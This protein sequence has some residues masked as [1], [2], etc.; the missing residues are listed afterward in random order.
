M[1]CVK[2]NT[3]NRQ[4]AK[5]C[6]QCGYALGVQPRPSFLIRHKK[7][8]IA[9]FVVFLVVV[10]P[11]FLLFTFFFVF[12]GRFAEQT[13]KDTVVSGSGENIIALVH[14]DGIIVE[15]EPAGGIGA[16]AQESTSVRKMKKILREAASS[17]K[18]KALFLKINSPGGSAAASE[19]IYQDLL[20]FK[21]ESGKKIVAYVSDIAAS[22]GYYVAMAAD[23]V[24][25]NPASITGSIGVMISYLNVEALAERFGVKHIVYK[26]GPFKDLLNEFRKPTEEESVIIQNVVNESYENFMRVVVSGRQLP[27]QE[28]RK[29]A[30]GR[31]YS[32]QQAK[33]LKLIDQIGTFEDAVVQAKS[34][35]SL[36]EASVVEFGQPS[37]WELFLGNLASRF[38]ISLSPQVD[39]FFTMGPGLRVLYL[40][41]P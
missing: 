1:N 37:F 20:R 26:T 13:E 35:V 28:V 3:S 40:Y 33:K 31:I 29:I 19:E 14:I 32:A 18:V 27:P 8:V 22:G 10:L 12:L 39:K 25:A 2:C 41:S 5:F 38:S 16:I 9:L 15:T 24:I 34:M 23:T 6:E 7:W 36:K 11:L 21:K 4:E 17:K 30:D